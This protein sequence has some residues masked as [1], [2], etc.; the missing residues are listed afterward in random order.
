MTTVQDV[1]DYMGYDVVDEQITKNATRAL[2]TAVQTLKGAIGDDV[3]EYLG[4]DPRVH[5]LTCIYAD[6]LYSERGLSP[7]VSSAT[8]RLVQSMEL[9]LRMELARLKAGECCDL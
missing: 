6:D 7:K 8:R 4:D 5:E 1:L 9:Q 2:N 3:E